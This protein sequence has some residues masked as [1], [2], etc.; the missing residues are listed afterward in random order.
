M[1]TEQEKVATLDADA[2]A[3]ELRR[4]LLDIARLGAARYYELPK[5]SDGRVSYEDWQRDQRAR[6]GYKP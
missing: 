6:Y 1:T 4:V 3:L 5:Q 2:S